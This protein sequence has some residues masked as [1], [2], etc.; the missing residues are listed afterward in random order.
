MLSEE[1]FLLGRD[2]TGFLTTFILYNVGGK[3]A[4]L[5]TRPTT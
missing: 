1:I 2:F 4:T 5:L 3:I